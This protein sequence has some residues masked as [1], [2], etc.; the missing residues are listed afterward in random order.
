VKFLHA[1]AMV[2]DVSQS[3]RI[4]SVPPLACFPGQCKMGARRSTAVRTFVANRWVGTR[5]R[6]LNLPDGWYR[7]LSG[8]AKPGDQCLNIDAFW[9]TGAVEWYVLTNPAAP[10]DDYGDADDY[11]CLIR[12]GLPVE[13]LCPRCR[14]APVRFGYRYCED[15]CHQVVRK[16]WRIGKPGVTTPRP[17]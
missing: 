5:C 7:V 9:K 14:D 1:M 4:A 3:M 13:V 2:V 16:L 11:C 15:C 8:A 17:T 10:G 12:R 6:E